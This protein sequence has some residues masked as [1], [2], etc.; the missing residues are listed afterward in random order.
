MRILVVF[1][2]PAT[3]SF[4]R[5]ILEALAARLEGDG[6]RLRI[7]D[8]Y[9]ESFD[10]VLDAE[11]WRAHRSDAARP[12]GL[13]D[14]I[15]ALRDAEGLVFLYP[16]WW[17]GPPAMLKGWLDRVWQPGVAFALE[18]GVFR[19]HYLTR[20]RRFAALTTH[21]SPRW[22][23]ERIVGDPA[24]RQFVRG[25]A[26]QFA[27]GVKS[28]WRPIYDVDRRSRG[29]DLARARERAVAHVARHFGRG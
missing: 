1:C 10:P 14:H 27:R 20:T 22:F 11:S 26:L 17:Y 13:S 5:S 3:E 2:H 28:C 29:A 21:G 12:D 16:T 9:A 19:T 8:L 25:L 6:H 18:N 24:R 4:L 7:L 23:I 15:A